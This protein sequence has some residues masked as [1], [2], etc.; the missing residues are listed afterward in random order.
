MEAETRY[1]K[2]GDVH[3]AYQVVG[4]GPLNVVFVPGFVSNVDASWRSPS[5]ARF[6]RR[7]AS[8]SRLILFDK[9]GTGLSDRA[10]QVFTLEQ[11]MEDMLAVMDAAACD[12]AVLFGISEGG[13]M[14]ILFAATYPDRTEAL[15]M[16]GSYARRSWA[17]DYPYGWR[18]AEWDTM[19]NNIANHWGTPLGMD[20]NVWAP[21]IVGDEH[22]AQEMA[23]Y[24][25]SA[26]S[27][28][29]VRA[30]MEMNR[31]IDVRH[32]LHAVQVPALVL[33]RT[34]DRHIRVEQGRDMA[35]GLPNARFVELEG[36]DHIPWIGH[37]DAILDEVQEFLTGARQGP[38]LNRVFA[39]I[40]FTD[41]VAS[42]ETASRLGDRAW[43]ELIEQH[44]AV[45]RRELARFRGREIRS[46]G[47]GLLAVFDG[48]VRAI[49]CARAL[50]EAVRPLGIDIRAGV[51]AG[52]IELVGE[53]VAGIA[54]HVGARV[55][56]LAR[57]SEVLVSSTVKDLVAGSGH[58]FDSR[59]THTLKGVEGSWELFAV[60]EPRQ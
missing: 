21:S 27:P 55:A 13:P 17:G 6:Y 38:D 8:F 18:Q 34:G 31:E 14:S 56:S 46:T 43:R 5:R 40:L 58:E 47:D 26:A 10:S 22:A 7:L 15:I 52:E 23:T 41:I 54:V 9:R 25:R 33:H 2:S 36:D 12:R 59:G 3:I 45:G 30:V 29:A 50:V 16:Y 49:H 48:P 11:R 28:G 20:L 44:H 32:V 24:M 53:D 60:R 42:T 51:H 4:G 35:S 39:T 37:S 1:T 19:L 57:S